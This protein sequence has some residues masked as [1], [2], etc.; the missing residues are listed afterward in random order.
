MSHSKISHIFQLVNLAKL[1]AFQFS[2]T[3]LA[4]FFV[5][6]LFKK[7]RRFISHAKPIKLLHNTKSPE[8]HNGKLHLL[9]NA[10][11]DYFLWNVPKLFKE[12]KSFTIKAPGYNEKYFCVLRLSKWPCIKHWFEFYIPNLASLFNCVYL[13]LKMS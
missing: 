9:R 10:E 4:I 11:S 1:S 8:I 7:S 6:S 2:H 5:Q 12:T 3:V 13:G